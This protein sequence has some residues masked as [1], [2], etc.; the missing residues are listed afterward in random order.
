MDGR[1]S[2]AQGLGGRGLRVVLR[3]DRKGGIGG[4]EV[5][6]ALLEVAEVVDAGLEDSE[7][8]HVLAVAGRDHVLQDAEFLVHLG[9][10]PAFDQRV[11]R[12]AR[13]LLACDTGASG[14]FPGGG[15]CGGI[16][17]A[18]LV[19]GFGAC[20]KC[21]GLGVVQAR[22]HLYDLARPCW[23]GREGE[24]CMCGLL[25]LLLLCAWDS[26]MLGACRFDN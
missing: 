5:R 24:I 3:R 2:G 14:G 22:S 1:R 19:G 9:A 21:G 23:R 6:N 16:G 13:D 11:G 18:F 7:L 20:G 17:D 15:C 12:L 4:F 8:V 10:P 25:R 26:A